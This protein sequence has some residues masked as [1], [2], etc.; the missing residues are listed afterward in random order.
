MPQGNPIPTAP[1]ISP[2]LILRT[3][4]E[5]DSA[6]PRSTGLSPETTV[7][8]LFERYFLPVY[9]R[10]RMADPKTVA[11]YRTAVH[12]WVRF[13]WDP[14]LRLV[15]NMACAAFVGED[16]RPANGRERS[17]NTVRKHCVALQMVLHAGGPQTKQHPWAASPYGLFGED[18]FG[19]PRPTPWFQK[20]PEREKPAEDGLTLDEIGRLL[21]VVARAVK[22]VLQEC[23]A[24]AWWRGL[25]KFGYNSGLRRGSLLALR[26]SWIKPFGDAGFLALPARASKKGLAKQIYLSPDAMAVLAELPTGDWVFPWPESI[27]SFNRYRQRLWRQADI[28]PGHTLHGLRKAIGSELYAISPKAAQLQLGHQSEATTRRSYVSQASAAAS[29]AANIGPA[30]RRV[31]QPK[32]KL[33]D[34]QRLL[35]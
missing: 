21:D 9:L 6:A 26:R 22:P 18:P 16:L 32:P 11:E 25:L 28:P 4:D 35:F 33:A 34:R 23:P 17:P 13:T 15:D 30:S 2:A 29:L 7:S 20:P 1:A 27:V 31:R 12:H 8:Q 3:I 14:P 19:R 24:P 10:S 5:L